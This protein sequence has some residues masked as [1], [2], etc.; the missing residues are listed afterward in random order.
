ML[1]KRMLNSWRNRLVSIVQLLIPILFCILA[2]LVVFAIPQQ[3]D[4]PARTLN[5]NQYP[6]PITYWGTKQTFDATSDKKKCFEEVLK[7]YKGEKPFLNDSS[8]GYLSEGSMD[9]YLVKKARESLYI[10]R[11]RYQLAG[12]IGK[13]Y[14][15]GFYN[16]ESYHTIAMSLSMVNNAWFK[17]LTSLTRSIETINHPL[18]WSFNSKAALDRNSSSIISFIFGLLMMFGMAFLTATFI[19][20]LIQEKMSGAKNSQYVSGVST[21]TFWFSTFIWDYFNYLIPV[22]C[23]VIVVVIS[24]AEGYT[25]ENNAGYAF[26][27]PI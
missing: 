26:V 22:V 1:V 16:D 4:P 20:F 21:G 24:R 5:V 17:C 15:T 7:G 13:D 19:V 8:A 12:E 2:V 9:N 3:E 14:F 27:V 6:E 23:V 25:H 11:N 18:P 10:Y